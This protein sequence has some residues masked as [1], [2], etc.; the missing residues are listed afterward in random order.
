MYNIIVENYHNQAFPLCLF[1]NDRM[2]ENYRCPQGKRKKYTSQLNNKLEK[3]NIEK[4][5]E[6]I[7]VLSGKYVVMLYVSRYLEVIF[8]V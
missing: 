3:M 7:E 1:I 2:I 8:A 5:G 4:I 6:Q